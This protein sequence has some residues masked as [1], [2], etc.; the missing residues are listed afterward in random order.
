MPPTQ[1][2]IARLEKQQKQQKT[3]RNVGVAGV[4]ML[5]TINT[6]A[7]VALNRAFYTEPQLNAYAKKPSC[8]NVQTPASSKSGWSVETSSRSTNDSTRLGCEQRTAAYNATEDLDAQRRMAVGTEQLVH[9]SR[10]TYFGTLLI[11]V[12]DVFLILATL[13]VASWA[14]VEARRAARAAENSLTQAGENGRRSMRAYVSCC[15]RTATR[16]GKTAEIE[17][18]LKNFGN[19]PAYK[20]AWD[21]DVW[22]GALSDPADVPAV[23]V[24][25]APTM[26]L[27][28]SDTVSQFMYYELIEDDIA[29]IESGVS[30][31]WCTGIVEYLDTFNERC[32]TSFRFYA[33]SSELIELTAVKLFIG[34]KGNDSN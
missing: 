17:I 18:V 24:S 28:P 16:R 14:A 15:A 30:A 19:T 12:L 25:N 23:E 2:S 27:P 26:N 9:W 3:I 10:S 13:V 21:F 34:D 33:T 6:I 4:I 20:L 29:N 22:V 1:A 7:G 11:G 5:I 32:F 31:L 8:E